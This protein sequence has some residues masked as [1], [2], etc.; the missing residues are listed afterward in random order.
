[1]T[2][3]IQIEG[4][5]NAPKIQVTSSSGTYMKINSTMTPDYVSVS[6]VQTTTG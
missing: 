2:Y 1:M 4:Y 6:D 3:P 5:S